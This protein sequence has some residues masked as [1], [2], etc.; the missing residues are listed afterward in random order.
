MK[1]VP[2]SRR[3]ALKGLGVTLALPW[4]EAM[5]PLSATAASGQ[6]FAPPD[7][8]A[9]HAERCAARRLDAARDRLQV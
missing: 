9:L 5:R 7:G 4:L 6:R 2:I 8:C 1:T 3:T